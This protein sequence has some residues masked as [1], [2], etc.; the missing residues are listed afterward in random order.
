[1][2]TRGRLG[3]L[4]G[5][6]GDDAVD[7]VGEHGDP[8]AALEAHGD[9]GPTIGPAAQRAVDLGEAGRAAEAGDGEALAPGDEAERSGGGGEPQGGGFHVDHHPHPL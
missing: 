8:R 2:R 1:M 9:R 6:G 3:P 4:E 5:V 7:H